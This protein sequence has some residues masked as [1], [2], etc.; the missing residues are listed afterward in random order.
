VGEV[1]GR[2]FIN[3]S[4]IGLYPAALRE[5]EK[6]Y[7][8]FGRSRLMAYLAAAV[9]LLRG[10]RETMRVRLKADGEEQSLRSPFVFVCTNRDQLDFYK[11]RG[12]SCIDR[13]AMAVYFSP[14]LKP[15]QLLHVGFRMLTRRLDKAEEY[16][17]HC[18]RDLWIETRRPRVEVALDGERMWM[19]T[20]LHYRLHPEPIRVRV[21]LQE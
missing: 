5:R 19:T 4:S 3:N 2:I 18:A 1:N 14:P 20:P 8:R 9:V 12:R 11:I 15:L 6:A 16:E 10:R 21:P 7:R 13:G 17:A